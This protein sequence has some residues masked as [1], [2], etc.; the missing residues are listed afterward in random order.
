MHT[1]A[2][3]E[4][5]LA[6]SAHN[7]QAEHGLSLLIS[8][9]GQKILFDTGAS[10]AFADNARAL[11]LDLGEVDCVVISHHHYDHSGGLFRFLEINQSARIYLTQAPKGE[12]WFKALGLLRRYVGPDPELFS[13]FPDRFAFIDGFQ[14]I[15]PGVYLLPHIVSKYPR[16]K[17]NR[18]LYQVQGR[19]WA[20]DDFSHELILAVVENGSLAIFTGCGHSGVLNMI[21]TVRE[22]FP[23]LPIKAVIGGF[24]LI[25]LPMFNTM[26]GSR[27]EI[28]EIGK[29]VLSFGIETTYTGHCT[30][31]KAFSVLKGNMGEQ[32][33]GLHTG[34]VIEL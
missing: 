3:I 34:D 27:A 21:E 23:G 29:K 8:L 5:S 1:T 32:L 6:P 26:G 33:Q 12:P 22:K 17:G 4:N 24:H 15:L 16:P 9:N 19:K 30:G 7:L 14:E 20:P 13:T 25:G 18:Y 11:N 28:E 31:E 10:G 2:L